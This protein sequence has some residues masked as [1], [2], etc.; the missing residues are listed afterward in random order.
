MKR[1][2]IL[3]ELYLTSL[4]ICVEIWNFFP[5]IN[6][7]RLSQKFPRPKMSDKSGFPLVGTWLYLKKKKWFKPLKWTLEAIQEFI[8]PE[9]DIF[10]DNFD[11][12]RKFESM[13]NSIIYPRCTNFSGTAIR[14]HT[15]SFVIQKL[16]RARGKFVLKIGQNS[17]F[18]SQELATQTSEIDFLL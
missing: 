15:S 10:P 16:Y 8:Y 2:L 9:I 11:F 5:E 17:A 3:F 4:R 6:V 14:K 1:S 18:N 7:F 13:P 12:L